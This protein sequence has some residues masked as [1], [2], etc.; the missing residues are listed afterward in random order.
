MAHPFG[1][2]FIAR[3]AD[4]EHAQV[5]GDTAGLGFQAM[6]GRAVLGI[7]RGADF[8]CLVVFRGGAI[9]VHRGPAIGIELHPGVLDRGQALGGDSLWH[10]IA[11]GP[12]G[13]CT[14]QTGQ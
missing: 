11:V 1:E 10:H 3:L 9:R 6:T 4:I 2:P 14:D 7:G 5:G 12:D 8:H 13:T